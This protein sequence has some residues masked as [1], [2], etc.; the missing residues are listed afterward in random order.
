MKPYL[1]PYPAQLTD[2]PGADRDAAL[3]A[4][5]AKFADEPL[6]MLKWLALQSGSPFTASVADVRAL[7]SHPS[8]KI[9]NPNACYSL[10]GP[11]CMYPRQNPARHPPPPPTDPSP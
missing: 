2:L 3:A 5:A 4:F 9:T 11:F 6:V 8:F 1:C 7:M 10:F